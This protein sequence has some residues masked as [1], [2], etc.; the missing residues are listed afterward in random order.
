[1][2]QSDI[3]SRSSVFLRVEEYKRPKFEVVF[4]PVTGSFKLNEKVTVKGNAKAYAGSNIDDAV[5]TYR[6][7]REARFPYLPWYYRRGIYPSSPAMEI[8]FGQ[9]KTNE[10]G[11]FT[12]EFEAI[13]DLSIAPSTKPEFNYTIYADVTDITGETQSAK[14]YIRVGYIALHANIDLPDQVNSDSL[15]NL[16]IVTQNLNGQ[17]EPAKGSMVINSLK[18]P[19]QT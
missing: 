7:V 1:R 4:Q 6:V 19:D 11:E 15:K 16:K 2:L 9:T 18:T 12:L 8:A 17:P 14:Q 5:V 3:G 13:P 10:T